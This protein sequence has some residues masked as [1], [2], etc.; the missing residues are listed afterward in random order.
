ME[1]KPMN[2]K[3]LLLFSGLILAS[4]L[5]LLSGASLS[6]QADKK[7]SAAAKTEK[8]QRPIRYILHQKQRYVDLR[9]VADFYGMLLG[10]TA[11]GPV[12]FSKKSRVDLLVGKRDAR[13]NNITVTLLFPTIRKDDVVYISELDFIK[14]LDPSLR[15]KLPRLALKRIMIDPGHGGTDKGAPGPGVNEKD[16]NLQLAHQLAVRLR[17]FGFEIL[18]TRTADDT[19]ALKDRAD[20][21]EKYKPDMYL[22]IHCNASPSKSVTGIETWLL[23]PKGGQ[24]AQE[25]TPKTTFDKGNKFDHYNFRL[26]YEI[27]KAMMKTFP[28]RVDRGVKHS[29]FFVLRHATAPA[30]LME[31]G[32]I[33]NYAEGKSLAAAATQKKIIDAIILGLTGYVNVIR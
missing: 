6:A 22:S 11:T 20:F 33:S 2:K 12:L 13:I 3:R 5:L 31:V 14:V 10:K 19:V 8:K 18:M 16:V 24:S 27:Q 17:A 15:Q 29:R 32:F 25:S 21:C 4:A 1:N 26:A 9:D 28:K 7:P 30:V 23:A